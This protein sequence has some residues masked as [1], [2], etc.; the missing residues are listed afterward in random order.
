MD[1][2][3]AFGKVLKTHRLKRNLSQASLA[4]LAH[5][6]QTAVGLIERNQRSPSLDTLDALSRSLDVPLSNLIDEA[7]KIRSR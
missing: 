1:L 6:D 7:E 5:I 2:T 3:E 4:K